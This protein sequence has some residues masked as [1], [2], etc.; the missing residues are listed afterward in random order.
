MHAYLALCCRSPF[1]EEFRNIPECQS[2][3]TSMTPQNTGVSV[4]EE[5]RCE[6]CVRYMYELI[7]CYSTLLA[8][9]TKSYGT[10]HWTTSSRFRYPW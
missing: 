6:R 9:F 4:P 5:E 8:E 1:L 10:G 3:A 2:I 7:S